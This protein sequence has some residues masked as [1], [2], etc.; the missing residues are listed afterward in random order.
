M[1]QVQNVAVLISSYKRL[2]ELQ[3]QIYSMVHQTHAPALILVV[4]KGF[5]EYH[6]KR[7]LI[8]KFEGFDN[9]RIKCESNKNQLCNLLDCVRGENFEKID[10]FLKIDDD[11]FYPVD[12]IA[13]TVE[14][15]NAQETLP[16]GHGIQAAHI[17]GRFNDREMLIYEGSHKSC[18]GGT[19]GFTPAILEKLI[20]VARYDQ[21]VM[22][23]VRGLKLAVD[24]LIMRLADYYGTFCIDRATSNYIYCNHN[25]SCWRNTENYLGLDDNIII[26]SG[27]KQESKESFIAIKQDGAI[28]TMRVVDNV[29]EN[30]VDSRIRGKCSFWKDVM[31]VE[32]NHDDMPAIYHHYTAGYYA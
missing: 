6:I 10:Y 30:P 22:P 27:G 1:N 2:T 31:V 32:W 20:A 21:S 18:W 19:L 28:Y 4:V 25:S 8:P 23:A 26:E 9:V 5:T 14:W 29:I 13:R 3:H 17:I 7:F 24:Q 11:D 12:Y 16:A 15:L